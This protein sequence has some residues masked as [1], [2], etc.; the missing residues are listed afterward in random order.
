MRSRTGVVGW[1]Q[2]WQ[3]VPHHCSSAVAV[4]PRFSGGSPLS[5]HVATGLGDSVA[6]VATVA[7]PWGKV[8]P[9]GSR[10][11]WRQVSGGCRSLS[12]LSRLGCVPG[13][14][15]Q[16]SR[17]NPVFSTSSRS[18]F[19]GPSK[20]PLTVA[21]GPPAFFTSADLAMPP[22]WRQV[23]L[24]PHRRPRRPRSWWRRRGRPRAPP[25][26]SCRPRRA[27]RP[28]RC[29]RAPRRR[30]RR[31][32]PRSGT[33]GWAG[34]RGRGCSSVARGA[35]RPSSLS[36]SRMQ[37][38]T[39]RATAANARDAISAVSGSVVPDLLTWMMPRTTHAELVGDRA[40]RLEAAADLGVL[41]GVELVGR[42]GR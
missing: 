13:R 12:R 33:R 3:T 40:D 28:G 32:R 5:R 23:V 9:M 6:T 1:P 42:A 14:L 35:G 2:T 31:R 20:G 17:G 36:G 19:R 22:F 18:L 29:R 10:P 38:R 30:R 21:G 15:H 39:A 11:Q 4:V 27:T 8:S 25:G 37:N 26:W 16:V 24:E 7:T 41:V 34:R